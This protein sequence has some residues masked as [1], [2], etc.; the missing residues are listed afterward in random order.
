MLRDRFYLEVRANL[1]DIKSFDFLL[2]S[3]YSPLEITKE[4]D[5]AEVR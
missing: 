1:E 3:F 5:T 2:S 4:I